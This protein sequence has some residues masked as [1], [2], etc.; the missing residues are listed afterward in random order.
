MVF[1]RPPPEPS[2]QLPASLPALRPRPR[3]RRSQ[4]VSSSARRASPRDLEGAAPLPQ[5][6]FA[7]QLAGMLWSHDE[8][9]PAQRKVLP[10]RGQCRESQGTPTNGAPVKGDENKCRFAATAPLPAQSRDGPGTKRTDDSR[11]SALRATP[12]SIRDVNVASRP[13]PPGHRGVGRHGV[14][15]GDLP[16]EGKGDALRLL[17]HAVDGKANRPHDR[18]GIGRRAFAME[19][20]RRLSPM[21][22]QEGD[23]ELFG[24][25]RACCAGAPCARPGAV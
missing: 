23:A 5:S 16:I 8:W 3:Q 17:R 12:C 24:V 13:E 11:G 22:R 19:H 25:G 14:T 15:T 6:A 18:A 7:A 21:Q 10:G 2:V 4:V 9:P 20:C 1:R